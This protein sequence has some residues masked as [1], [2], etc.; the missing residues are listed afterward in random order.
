MKKPLFPLLMVILLA[1]NGP[2]RAGEVLRLTDMEGEE[3]QLAFSPNGDRIAFSFC[4]KGNCDI[5]LKSIEEDEPPLQITKSEGRES[6][7]TWSP[8]GKML[9]Y[10]VTAKSRT[11][12]TIH[13]FAS[14]QRTLVQLEGAALYKP[15][16]SPD[17]KRIVLNG[18]DGSSEDIYL[19]ELKT[20]KFT[21]LTHEPGRE[22]HFG[23]SPDGRY[24]GYNKRGGPIEDLFAISV[25]GKELINITQHAGHE[26]YPH[27][28]PKGDG[29]LFYS[30]WGTEMTEVWVAN[31]P[32]TGLK[33][34][35]DHI[36]E[37]YGP[38]FSPDGEEVVFISKRDGLNDLYVYHFGSDSLRH[39]HIG[40]KL[41][42]GWPLWSPDRTKLAY[43]ANLE[44][45]HL[46]QITIASGNIRRLTDSAQAEEFPAMDPEGNYVAYVTKGA[47]SE[48][49]IMLLHLGTGETSPFLAGYQGQ[50]RP[51]FSHTT[52]RLGLVQSPGGSIVTNNIITA[53]LDGTD[54]LQLTDFGGV[55]HF[56]WTADDKEIIY[57]YDS[58]ANYA[59]DIWKLNL[60]TGERQPLFESPADG[61]PTDVSVNGA[62]FLFHSNLGGQNKIYRMPVAGGSPEPIAHE[63]VNGWGA[64]YSPDGE[65]IVFL[66]DNNAEKTTDIYIMH[67]DGGP[68][69]RLT[70]DRYRETSP[71]WT[72]DGKSIIFSVQKGSKDIWVYTF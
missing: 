54:S 4:Q 31:F 60:P 53:S 25:D 16:W 41:K 42:E 37:D 27:W 6:R 3:E 9:A 47:G 52:K 51:Q 2:Y 1:C 15:G 62:H 72:V 29:V 35:S 34:V 17:G 56:I 61:I 48:S 33:R 44:E 28:S 69:Q 8:N 23:F 12:I 19:Y 63:L 26:W 24:V 40:E 18:N 43:S 32:G 20:A 65:Q 30:T 46:Y 5:Y 55:R 58:V 11:Y 71:K 67:R 59:Y 38:V 68:V 36:V 70:T 13:E 45:P 7:P 49:N 21:R 10:T 66:S 50:T 57:A 64:N 39:L 22:V 14:K